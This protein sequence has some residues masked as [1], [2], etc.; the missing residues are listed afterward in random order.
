MKHLVAWFLGYALFTVSGGGPPAD[1]PYFRGPSGQGLATANAIPIRWDKPAWSVAVPGE[2]WSSPIVSRGRV[3]LTTATDGG[4]SCRVLAYDAESGKLAWEREVFRIQPGHKEPKNSYATPTAVADA[5]RIYTV[6]GDGS[7][8]ALDHDGKVAWINR[9]YPHYSQHGLGASPILAGGLLIMARDGS[10]EKEDKKLGWQIPW[11]RSFVLALDARTGK[12]RWRTGRGE[13]RIGHATPAL[14]GGL[15]ISSAGDVVQA[16]DPATG[17]LAWTARSQGEGVVPSAVAGG[18]LIFTCSGFE[19][20]TIRAHR[21]DGTLAWEQTRGVPMI[22]SL[23]HHD[24]L[25]YSI[26]QNGIAWCFRATTGEPVWQGRVGGTH[27]ASP[28]LANG[29]VYFSSEEGEVTVIAAGAE[30]RIEAVN[31]VAVS[32]K[33]QASPAVS[34]HTLYLRTQTKLL[35][36]RQQ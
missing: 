32:E 36:I 6:F 20:P 15:I 31:P 2:G 7:F 8:A 10:N 27:S 4:R 21:A 26:T 19:K 28:I 30:F 23:L 18:G 12:E 24:G 13:S 33:M 14:V 25:L 16:F 35:A 5:E 1:W 9:D 11:D 29:H 3:I 22:S 17:R 34:G